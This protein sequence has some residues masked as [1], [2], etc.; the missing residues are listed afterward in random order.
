LEKL[1]E[2]GALEKE[3]PYTNKVGYS[4]R[5]DVPIE[6]RLSE[7]WFLKYPSVEQARNCVAQEGSATVPVAASGVAGWL[8][9]EWEFRSAGRRTGRTGRPRSPRCTF[10]RSGGPRFMTTGWK[11]SRDWC[12]SRQLW[13]GHRIPVWKAGSNSSSL[14]QTSGVDLE[15]F[16]N[17]LT[18]ED[19]RVVYQ[20][21]PTGETAELMYRFDRYVAVAP[22]RE[23]V[24]KKLQE[25]GFTQD[26]DVLDTWFSSWLWPFA[27]M[28][29]PEQT[30]TL[31]KFYPTTDLVTGPDIIFF[32]VARMIMAGYEFMGKCPSRM[33]ILQG[34]SAT[35]R[36][37]KCPRAWA[38]RPIRWT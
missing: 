17:Q 35:S 5:A 2:L 24:V 10:I 19:S 9:G 11:A 33:F 6:P 7:Q 13:W 36:A 15:S 32:W 1:K 16:L 14:A 38:I 25:L 8:F 18:Q 27:T 26:P 28:G 4:E 20:R 23:D 29:W 21:H 34:S 37:G 3:E 12:I 22:G 31:K 30:D